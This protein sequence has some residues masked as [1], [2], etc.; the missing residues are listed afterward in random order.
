M[1]KDLRWC[2]GIVEIV[3]D[4]TWIKPGKKRQCYKEGEAAKFWDEIPECNL[5][6]SRSI[7]PFN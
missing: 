6:A 3:C 2:S 1:N 4:G 7:D 5:E